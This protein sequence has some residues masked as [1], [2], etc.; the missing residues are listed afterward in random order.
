MKNWSDNFGL[1]D[2]CPWEQD[3]EDVKKIAEHLRIPWKVF[4]FEREYKER[5]LDY[6]FSEYKAGRTPNPDIMCNNLIKFDL[7]ANRA[8]SE[9]ATHIATG[10]Y[11]RRQ[12]TEGFSWEK[13]GDLGLF[14]ALDETKDQG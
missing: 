10:H 13:S 4:N 6:F 2:N 7:F 12:S 9:G 1:S 11:A 3:V 14:T 8:F 5:V